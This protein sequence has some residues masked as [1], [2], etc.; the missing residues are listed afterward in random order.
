[1]EHD[2]DEYDEG[3]DYC[4][5]GYDDDNDFDIDFEMTSNPQVKSPSFSPLPVQSGS[6]YQGT[7][8]S[9][10]AGGNSINDRN[11]S[12]FTP[13][14]SAGNDGHIHVPVPGSLKRSLS[15]T[16]SGSL[17]NVNMPVRSSSFQAGLV[18]PSFDKSCTPIRASSDGSLVRS[19]DST[20]S[21]TTPSSF[22]RPSKRA[23]RSH[24][25]RR[26]M[27]KIERKLP[28]GHAFG[29]AIT[30]PAISLYS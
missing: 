17:S 14:P 11:T 18:S 12:T 6:S 23:R 10:V 3:D 7:S 22:R 13:S 29:C 15:G 1:L 24:R 26:R 8:P 4:G 27:A 28:F 25:K 9:F 5:V 20:P 19:H 2:N 16:F 30:I 21:L